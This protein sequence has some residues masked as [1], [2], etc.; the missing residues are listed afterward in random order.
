MSAFPTP[1]RGAIRGALFFLSALFTVCANAGSWQQNQ[2]VGGFNS[3]HIYTPDSVSPIGDGKALLIMLHGCAQ[4]INNFL[5]ANLEVAAEQ[6]GMVVAVPDAMN[7]AGFSC[8]SYWEGVKSRTSADYRNLVNLA[9]TMSGDASR[10]IDP[11]QV[12]IAGLSSGAAFAN[13]TACLAPDVFAGMGI[14]AGPSVGTSSNGALGPCEQADVTT[15]CNTYAGSYKS[16]FDTQIA[17]IAHGDADTTVNLCYNEQNSDG[18]AGVYGVSKLSGTNT[19]SEGVG[20]TAEETLWE[21]GRVSKLLFNGVDHAWSGGEGASGGYINGNGINYA[22]YLGQFFTANN[23]RVDRNSG[24]AISNLSATENSGALAI[25]GNAL[26]AEGSVA[27]VAITISNVDGG[28][29]VVVETLNASAAP[30][31]GF[32]SATSSA[33]ADGLYEVSAVA[34]DNESVQGD[35][36]A[37]TQRVGPEPPESAP[38]LSDTATTVSGQ[39]ATV[40]GTVVDANQNLDSVV[41]DFANG[42][43]SAAI[44]GSSYSAEGCNLPGGSNQATVTATDATQLSSTDT[45]SFDIDAGQTGDYNFH[46][47]AGHITWGVGYSACYLAFG[48]SEFTMREYPSG[49]DCQWIADGDSSCAGPVQACS[50]GGGSDGGSGG[51][52]TEPTDSDGDGVEDTLDNC[53]NDVNPG[54]ADNDS[55]GIGNACDSTPDGEPVDADG[56]GVTDSVDNCPNTANPGQE[57]SDADGIGDACDSTPNG[58]VTCTEYTAN[59]YNHVQAGR[60]TTTGGYTYAVGSGDNLGLYNLFVTTTLAETS[61]GYYELGNCP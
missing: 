36:A 20:R 55:D 9:N 31:D 26:D 18:M 38:V 58:D 30:S 29:P 12:Y 19:V 46:I 24:P 49:S 5:T 40:T 41:V 56:D 57:D 32:F 44:S 42:N 3:V 8:W 23:Q 7:K 16:H 60:A 13:T 48:T 35:A 6:Y 10:N 15:R 37:V 28:A 2:S 50:A 17:S 11:D 25:S 53:P 34:T 1:S 47:S 14:S 61:A 59:N 51:G 43:V 54:Q 39:C 21:D 52:G 45:I 33:L 22:S 27:D 4:P